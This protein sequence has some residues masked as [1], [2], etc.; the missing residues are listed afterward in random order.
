MTSTH[1]DR[2]AIRLRAERSRLGLSQKDFARFAGVEVNAQGH[3]ERGERTPRADY[4]AAIS[5]IG[6]DVGY[7]VTG[8]ARS[9]ENDSLSPREGSVVRAFRNLADTDQEALSLI[10]EKLSHTNG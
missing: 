8:V 2:F 7:L 4:L 9:I 10:L 6:V 3:Y 5:A 1:E